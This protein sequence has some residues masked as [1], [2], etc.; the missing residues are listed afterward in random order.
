MGCH[1]CKELHA[2]ILKGL[3]SLSLTRWSVHI[4][5][6][7]NKEP[8]GILNFKSG[9]LVLV[10]STKGSS[11]I[12]NNG[13]IPQ[14]GQ[15]GVNYMIYDRNYFSDPL[16]ELPTLFLSAFSFSVYMLCFFLKKKLW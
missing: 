3:E 11:C 5:K 8:V 6:K 13:I 14:V 16:F 4:S 9:W 1:C 7:H 15:H 12:T 10:S 2:H